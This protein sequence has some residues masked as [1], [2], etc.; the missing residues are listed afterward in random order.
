MPSSS[1]RVRLAVAADAGGACE[2]VRRSIVEL[3]ADDHRGDEETIAL[4]IANKTPVQFKEWISATDKVALVAEGHIGIVG[5][6]LLLSDATVALLYVHPEARFS[7]VSKALLAA[8]E[9]AAAAFGRPDVRLT[10]SETARRFYLACGY[11][12][13]GEPTPGFARI[14]AHPMSKRLSSYR[15]GRDE[16][17]RPT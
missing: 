9:E 5:F 10:S 1:Y 14:L 13:S 8:M 17:T 6:G 16:P 7:G 11:V 12:P 4:W 15:M 3:C 2:A